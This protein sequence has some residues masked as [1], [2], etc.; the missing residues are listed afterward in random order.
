MT[1]FIVWV[2]HFYTN[3]FFWFDEGVIGSF[4]PSWS[5]TVMAGGEA[6]WQNRLGGAL[7]IHGLKLSLLIIYLYINSYIAH[8]VKSIHDKVE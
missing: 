5:A 4:A 1:S 2:F 7:L 6:N 3:Q 8:I